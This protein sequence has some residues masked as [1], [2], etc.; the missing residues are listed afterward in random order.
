MEEL[1]N[2]N[3]LQNFNLYDIENAILRELIGHERADPRRKDIGNGRLNIDALTQEEC[4]KIVKSHDIIFKPERV[5]CNS[6]TKTDETKYAEAETGT[7][8]TVLDNV[9][10]KATTVTMQEILL[11]SDGD[12]CTENMEQN[13]TEVHEVSRR[14]TKQPNWMTS[15]EYVVNLALSV[16]ENPIPPNTKDT[17]NHNRSDK[18]DAMSAREAKHKHKQ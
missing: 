11:D 2:L 13:L 5:C 3:A 6:S 9:E 14:K 12:E 10:N 1:L 17:E 16:V 4:K 7:E 8:A 15:G 18:K